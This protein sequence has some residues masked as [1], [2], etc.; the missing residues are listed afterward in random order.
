PAGGRPAARPGTAGATGRV[1]SRQPPP[2]RAWA[3]ASAGRPEEGEQ[4]HGG[5]REDKGVGHEGDGPRHPRTEGGPRRRKGP[6]GPALPPPTLT[7]DSR[8]PADCSAR[9]PRRRAAGVS[10]ALWVY[11]RGASR[12]SP[13]QACEPW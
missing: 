1:V 13:R 8:G 11:L 4:G 10:L 3:R 6:A 7:D 5:A 9:G 12:A 2:A